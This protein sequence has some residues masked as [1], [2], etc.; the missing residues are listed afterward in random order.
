MSLALLTWKK[1][2]H[3][4]FMVCDLW[5]GQGA[6]S[7]HHN[8][9]RTPRGC[10]LLIYISLGW[11]LYMYHPPSPVGSSIYRCRLFP[12]HHNDSKRRRRDLSDDHIHITI[13]S[14]FGFFAAVTCVSIGYYK[15]G[16]MRL[17]HLEQIQPSIEGRE[18]TVLYGTHWSEM[19]VMWEVRADEYP[20]PTSKWE[21]LLVRPRFAASSVPIHS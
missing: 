12:N 9:V 4:T 8:D 3:L 11:S 6:W 19:P 18:T 20:K 7:Y 5:R 10:F 14:L 13:I 17:Q 16:S 2:A 1:A 15:R 21:D